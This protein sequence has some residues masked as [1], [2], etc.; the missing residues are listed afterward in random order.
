MSSFNF[1]KKPYRAEC[2]QWIGNNFDHIKSLLNGSSAV[3]EVQLFRD[4]YVVIRHAGGVTTLSP[5]D[6]AILGEDGEPRFYTNEVFLA[7]YEGMTA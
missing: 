6:W 3:N 4:E 1:R 5:S 2:V 7:N